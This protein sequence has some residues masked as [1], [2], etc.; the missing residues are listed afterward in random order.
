MEDELTEWVPYIDSNGRIRCHRIPV[1]S[2]ES[3]DNDLIVAKSHGDHLLHPYRV[4]RIVRGKLIAN[5][6]PDDGTLWQ[7]LDVPDVTG[8]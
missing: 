1:E 4:Y 5:Y 8:Q 3:G 2:E 6:Y 7:E